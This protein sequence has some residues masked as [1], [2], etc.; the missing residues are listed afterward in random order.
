MRTLLLLL[1]STISTTAVVVDNIKHGILAMKEP[2]VQIV[3]AYWRTYVVI[4]EPRLPS[5]QTLD[6]EL[7]TAASRVERILQTDQLMRHQEMNRFQMRITLLRRLLQRK[8]TP[9]RVKRG[10]LN[11][12]GVILNKI[13]GTATEEQVQSLQK[14]VRTTLADG[15]IIRHQV[16]QMT[17]VINGAVREMNKTRMYL[18]ENRKQLNDMVEAIR[19]LTRI[20]NQTQWM[21]RHVRVRAALENF[22]GDLERRHEVIADLREQSFE[23]RMELESGRL[24][25]EILPRTELAAILKE[26][27]IHGVH[28]LPLTHYYETCEVIPTWQ[29]DDGLAYTVYLPLIHKQ[30]A[31]YRFHTL[32]TP[33]DRGWVEFML[34]PHVG[35][36]EANGEISIL[37]SCRGGNPNACEQ[38][39]TF[40]KGLLCERSLITQNTESAKHCR[41]RPAMPE[42]APSITL[43]TNDYALAIPDTNLEIRCRGLPTRQLVITPGAY[44]FIFPFRLCQVEGETGWTLQN[45]LLHN[46]YT[47]LT[48]TMINL[49]TFDIPKIPPVPSIPGFRA[50]EMS[51]IHGVAIQELSS[52]P[53]GPVFEPSHSWGNTMITV[54]VIAALAAI[55]LVVWCRRRRRAAAEMKTVELT[56]APPETLSLSALDDPSRATTELTNARPPPVFR[57]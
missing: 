36:D 40:P 15:Q 32:P 48:V 10:L 3:R 11:L 44:R 52:M 50:H 33:G 20:S 39:L 23:H 34:H 13:F 1:L 54:L 55:G 47:N 24:T 30:V 27:E 17:T 16:D 12:G 42:T 57:S 19:S 56:D 35:Y 4:S 45:T 8:N 7:D 5:I 46:V 37:E 31:S 22:I 41:I 26:A 38:R 29:S 2:D 49:T 14:L 51:Q 28:G 43:S 9:V 25:E 6:V 53:S 21:L 18:Q